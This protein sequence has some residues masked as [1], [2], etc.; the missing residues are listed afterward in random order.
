MIETQPHQKEKKTKRKRAN[1]RERR[2]RQQ[3]T[4]RQSIQMQ[5]TAWG[6]VAAVRPQVF[7]PCFAE[8]ALDATTYAGHRPTPPN[9]ADGLT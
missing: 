3:Q 5:T 4:N 8:S 6:V 9:T 2:L 7:V 1:K